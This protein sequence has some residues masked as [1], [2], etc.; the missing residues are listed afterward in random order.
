MHKNGIKPTIVII[1]GATG[2]LTKRKLLPSF[3]RL[4]SAGRLPR[5]FAII[6][7]SRSRLRDNDFRKRVRELLNEQKEYK[8]TFLQNI[9]YQPGF[10]E[11][12]NA[13]QL[14]AKRLAAIDEEWQMCSNKLF[15][16][17]VPP[18]SYSVILNNLAESGLTIPCGPDEGWTRV[19]I[20]KPFGR[21]LET[22]QKLDNLLGS[23]FR[24]EQVFRIDHYLAKETV[25]NILAFRFGNPIFEPVWCNQ[26]IE[27]IELKLHEISG[28][29]KRGVFYD[30]TGALRDVGQ[31]HLLQM[32]VLVTM[33]QPGSLASEAVRDERVK[34]LKALKLDGR[35]EEASQRAQYMGYLKEEG[36]KR[37]S[38]TETFFRLKLKINSVRWQGTPFY[39]EAGKKMAEKTT[40]IAVFFKDIPRHLFPHQTAA[41]EQNVL[42]FRVQPEPGVELRFL[43]KKPGLEMKLETRQLSFDYQGSF[44]DKAIDAY[45]KVIMDA[46]EGDTMLFARTDGLLA[47]WQII[48]EVLRCW[49]AGKVP[50]EEYEPG[51]SGPERRF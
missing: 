7:F 27:K 38:Q 36:V 4:F 34:V 40:S 32:L 16:L 29:E 50:L 22:A 43:V 12:K 45:D 17:A 10:F 5:N 23:L 11:D 8:E 33:N 46:I 39:I 47:S 24:E 30:E 37:G 3:A 48:T 9:F 2:D 18:S 1:F 25:Q 44:K 6:G 26:Y 28:I 35:A 31:N 19:L 42:C 41:K 13:Y 20:E 21:D 15:Y 14:L 49:E 51:T